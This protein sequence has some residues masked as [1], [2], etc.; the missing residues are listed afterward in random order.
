M[1]GVVEE[2]ELFPHGSEVGN[3]G[4]ADAGRQGRHGIA[5]RDGEEVN[6]GRASCEGTKFK[7]DVSVWVIKVYINV[8][9]VWLTQGKNSAG[10]EQNRVTRHRQCYTR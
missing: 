8:K 2:V 6:N 7:T 3:V 1:F 4:A 5:T 9:P 10:W